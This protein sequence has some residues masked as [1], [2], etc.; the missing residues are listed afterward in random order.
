MASSFTVDGTDLQIKMEW[1]GDADKI[2]STVL[3]AAHILHI[4]SG[5]EVAWED[6]TNQDKLDILYRHFTSVGL[7]LAREYVIMS[8]MDDARIVADGLFELENELGEL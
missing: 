6:L 1:V 7:A 5:G 2:A 4:R 8:A 3:N